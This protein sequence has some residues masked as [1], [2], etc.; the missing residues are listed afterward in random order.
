MLIRI[1]LTTIFPKGMVEVVQTRFCRVWKCLSWVLM[2]GSGWMAV[3]L[4]WLWGEAWLSQTLYPCLRS[5]SKW[6]PFLKEVSVLLSYEQDISR[7]ITARSCNSSSV[8][9]HVMVLLKIFLG[10]GRPITIRLEWQHHL[11]EDALRPI[12]ALEYLNF[13]CCRRKI[14]RGEL[15]SESASW[16]YPWP[17]YFRSL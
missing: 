8:G 12:G 14:V 9:A 7:M 6:F 11:S 17:W 4:W 15:S 3:P 1:K 5:M 10:Q 16:K 2:L 13:P